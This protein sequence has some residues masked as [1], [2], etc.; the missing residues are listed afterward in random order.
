MVMKGCNAL[1]VR[2]K[3]EWW[4]IAATSVMYTISRLR[5]DKNT[6]MKHA[7]MSKYNMIEY[8]D[9]VPIYTN[10]TLIYHN[11]EYMEDSSDSGELTRYKLEDFLD[12]RSNEECYGIFFKWFLPCVT[13]KTLWNINL[14]SATKD[15]DL[16]SV[17]DEAFCLLL[18]INSY[19]R[20]VDIYNKGL[21][22]NAKT[23]SE[24]SGG[25]I[26]DNDEGDSRNNP[27]DIPTK[28]T[29]KKMKKEDRAIKQGTRGWS[30]EG[31][32]VFNELNEKAK[33]DRKNSNFITRWLQMNRNH[34]SKTKKVKRKVPSILP[35]DDLFSSDEEDEEE[36]QE[37]GAVMERNNSPQ[38]VCVSSNDESGNEL[39]D[40]IGGGK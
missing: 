27:S 34:P 35:K 17:P 8:D 40:G 22:N 38:E 28:F 14:V 1:N 21:Y 5:N 9:T 15:S 11:L 32:R 13:G 26:E 4:K 6:A 31:I 37:G 16:A 23:Q 12:M 20:W 18:L 19:D 3:K 33:E 36:Q 39:D 24:D 25:N 30:Y 10:I 29:Y 2:K 7:F